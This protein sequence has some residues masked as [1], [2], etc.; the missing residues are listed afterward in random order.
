MDKLVDSSERQCSISPV[1]CASC[2]NKTGGGGGGGGR[3]VTP[4][5]VGVTGVDPWEG[6]CLCLGSGT[7]R[8]RV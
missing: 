3:E 7:G 8:E 4:P 5:W 2:V 6:L 1:H